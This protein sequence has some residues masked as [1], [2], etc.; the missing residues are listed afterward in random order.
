MTR[1]AIV[2]SRIRVEEKLLLSALEAAGASI[3]VVDDGEMILR[4][5]DSTTSLHADVALERS[6][7]TARGSLHCVSWR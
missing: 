3:Q 4:A 5:D 6:V 1:V 2:V 7:S